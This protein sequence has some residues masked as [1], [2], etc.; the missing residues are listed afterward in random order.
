MGRP[1]AEATRHPGRRGGSPEGSGGRAGR[2]IMDRALAG[3]CWWI[4]CGGAER[5]GEI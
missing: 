4:R 2:K 5:K 1:W 3:T